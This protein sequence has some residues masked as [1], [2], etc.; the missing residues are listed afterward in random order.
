MDICVTSGCKKHNFVNDSVYAQ[1][2][3]LP[4]LKKSMGFAQM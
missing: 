1:K 3:D 4:D 2:S